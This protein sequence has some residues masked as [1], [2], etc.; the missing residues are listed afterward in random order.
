MLYLASAAKVL[1]KISRDRN[2]ASRRDK[3]S[4]A[5]AFVIEDVESAIA[6]LLTL[7]FA[8]STSTS[9]NFASSSDVK[10]S[11]FY[12]LIKRLHK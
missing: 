5:I 2:L 8:D 1:S 11:H 3:I 12:T 9:A 7:I 4:K 6:L 10:Y